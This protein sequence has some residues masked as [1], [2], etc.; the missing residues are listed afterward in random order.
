[1]WRSGD[2]ICPLIL[3]T[4]EKGPK[5]YVKHVAVNKI[6]KKRKFDHSFLGILSGLKQ[7]SKVFAVHEY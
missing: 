6:D 5:S 2:S 4:T 7:R 3:V 1:M